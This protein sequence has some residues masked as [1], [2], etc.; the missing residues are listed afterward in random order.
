MRLAPAPAPSSLYAVHNGSYTC[1]DRSAFVTATFTASRAVVDTTWLTGIPDYTC[2]MP[3]STLIQE[4]G[5]MIYS[6]LR[7]PVRMVVRDLTRTL[8]YRMSL[9][10][11]SSMY[12]AEVA[13][14]CLRR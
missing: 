10:Y 5:L 6:N 7:H 3:V 12:S 2:N 4:P 14:S 1:Y 11:Q 8:P 13:Y 9:V